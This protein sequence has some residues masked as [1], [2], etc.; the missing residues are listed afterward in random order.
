K[1]LGLKAFRTSISWAELFPRGDRTEVP[2]E[3]GLP[4]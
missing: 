2:N 1:E 4:I 3:A